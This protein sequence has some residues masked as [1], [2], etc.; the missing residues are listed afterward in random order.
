MEKMMK[1][2]G[3]IYSL[4]DPDTK[5]IRYI[6]QTIDIKGRY[7]SHC[8]TFYNDYKSN[9]IKS[10]RNNSKLPLMTILLTCDSNMLNYYE[11][12]IIKKYRESCKLTNIRDGGE[13]Y[14]QGKD[15]PSSIE[16]DLWDIELNKKI[17]EFDTIRDCYLFLGVKKM[18]AHVAYKNNS[19]ISKKYKIVPR[20]GECGP[21]SRKEFCR[22]RKT[23]VQIS[24]NGKT[25]NISAWAE[26]Y[27]ISRKMLEHRVRSGW[28][29][30]LAITTPSRKWVKK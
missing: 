16:V 19:I 4:S 18:T 28:D 30:E 17:G 23:A 29:V 13:G 26:E 3:F 5:E 8:N 6:G 14:G 11:E 25:Q 1:I 22:L 10:L 15:N 20:N 7:S 24:F 27:G 9:W 12:L 2:D 21:K